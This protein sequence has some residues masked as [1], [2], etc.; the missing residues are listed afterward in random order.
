MSFVQLS[1]DAVSSDAAGEVLSLNI[2]TTDYSMQVNFAGSINLSG[3]S[4]YLE[5]SL[6]GVN[7]FQA[8]F[9]TGQ[10]SGVG[11]A[12]NTNGA[13]AQFIRARAFNLTGGGTVTAY[14]AAK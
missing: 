5:G 10:T 14:V 11:L 3:F 9:L 7:F 4:V 8:A 13:L 12:V 1:L 2:P 6:D